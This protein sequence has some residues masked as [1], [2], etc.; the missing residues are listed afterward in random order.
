[1]N[2]FIQKIFQLIILILFFSFFSLLV[3]DNEY[4]WRENLLKIVVNDRFLKKKKLFEEFIKEKKS[5]NLILGSSYIRDG[6]IPDSLG[7]KW[8]SFSNSGQTIYDG[9][10]FLKYYKD[11]VKVDTIIMGIEPFDFP[12]SL[13]QDNSIGINPN[14]IVFRSD[15]IIE[16]VKKRNKKFLFQYWKS[17]FY[18][19]TL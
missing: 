11:T 8:Y 1:M 13:A 15:S 17:L 3:V 6:I 18:T 19:I 4:K 10:K 14:F 16:F 9:Y 2:K 12:N 5:I 7:D